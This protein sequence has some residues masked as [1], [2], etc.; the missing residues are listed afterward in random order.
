[1]LVFM[2]FMNTD[3]RWG[4]HPADHPIRQSLNQ[5][6][7]YLNTESHRGTRYL[8]T[9]CHFFTRKEGEVHA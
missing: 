8:S 1:M 2:F 3:L 9:G 6:Q 5:H 7:R 4:K